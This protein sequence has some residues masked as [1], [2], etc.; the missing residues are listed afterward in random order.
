MKPLDSPQAINRPLVACA[1]LP[2]NELHPVVNI[3]LNGPDDAMTV[4][5]EDVLGRANLWFG[6]ENHPSVW[7]NHADYLRACDEAYGELT[8]A[9]RFR[10]FSRDVPNVV[11]VVRN[12]ERRLRSLFRHYRS[13]GAASIH[14]IDNGSSDRSAE[15]ALADP[16]VTLWKTDAGFAAGGFGQLWCGAIARRH[17]LGSWIL[18]VDADEHLAYV[19]MESRGLDQLQSW[20]EA[21][22]YE[23]LFTP[24]VDLYCREWASRACDGEQWTSHDLYFDGNTEFGHSYQLNNGPYGPVLLGGPRARMMASIGEKNS[25]WLSKFALAK[26][27]SNTAYANVH[28]P[29]PFNR[30]PRT[31]FG[32]LLHLKLLD[33]FEERV[34]RAIREDQHWKGA[35]EY[36]GYRNW[37]ERYRGQTCYSSKTSVKYHGPQCLVSA[38]ILRAIPWN[39][40]NEPI[41]NESS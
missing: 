22:G 20:L 35:S 24:L 9:S 16:L 38:G 11:C 26:W 2:V 1:S 40:C 4:W 32:A 18:N 7:L 14:V 8:L 6:R 29:Y 15:I 27:D 5:C 33:D 28:F 17:G 13:L 19:G 34:S 30:N 12:E 31:C 3:N 25:P 23:R 10:P 41:N 39:E 21:A 36:R 37:L